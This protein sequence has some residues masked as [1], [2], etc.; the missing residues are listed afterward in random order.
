MATEDRSLTVP[1]VTDRLRVTPETIRRWLRA[2]KL[3]RILMGSD[4]SGYRIR[5]S[6]IR[7]VA[8]AGPVPM[9]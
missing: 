8:S 1:E 6:E 2:G 7:R 5:E 9:E 3:Q 4:R